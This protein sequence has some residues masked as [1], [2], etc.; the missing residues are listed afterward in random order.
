MKQKFFIGDKINDIIV[1]CADFVANN[2]L[3]NYHVFTFR[4]LSVSELNP[5]FALLL[6]YEK[7]KKGGSSEKNS[8]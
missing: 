7:L 6:W 1:D 4:R 2:S 8:I 5:K 3:A